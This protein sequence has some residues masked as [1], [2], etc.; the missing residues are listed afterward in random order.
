VP[1]VLLAIA[2]IKQAF[3]QHGLVRCHGLRML[4]KTNVGFYYH[5]DMCNCL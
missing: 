5:E 4:K 1:A 2:M 3:D